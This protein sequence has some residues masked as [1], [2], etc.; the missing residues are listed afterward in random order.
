MYTDSPY[1]CRPA[2]HVTFK[3]TSV[4]HTR[5]NT[6]VFPLCYFCDQLHS[7]CILC[8]LIKLDF[9]TKLHSLIL[10]C[11]NDG[12]L[13]KTLREWAGFCWPAGQ[14]MLEVL[15]VCRVCMCGYMSASK[16]KVCCGGAGRGF[17]NMPWEVSGT[18]FLLYRGQQQISC[19]GPPSVMSALRLLGLQHG[20]P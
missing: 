16:P 20:N 15:A 17:Q 12:S 6:L 19:Q 11:E 3:C 9:V 10:F 2:A 14:P 13:R 5:C 18:P 4:L 7:A 8:P 1:R